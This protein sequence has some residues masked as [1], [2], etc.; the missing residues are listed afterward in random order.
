MSCK[1]RRS[2]KVS[3]DT[4]KNKKIEDCFSQVNKE[5][6]D[7]SSVPQMKNSSRRSPKDITNTQAQRP[8]D[9]AVSQNKVNKEQQDNS[10]VP[11]MK[12]SSRRSSR[13]ITNTQAQIP[14]DQVISQNKVFYVTLDVHHR[15]NK[16]MKH[17]VTGNERDSLSNALDTVKAV[18]E[19]RE[20]QQGKEMLVQGKEGIEGY[21][22]L[23]M[24]LSC[25]PANCHLVITFAQNKNEQSEE[26]QIFGRHD[27]ASTDCVIFFINPIG[28]TRKRIVRRGELHKEGIKLCVYA[29]KGET[30][31]EAVCKD[32][33]FLSFLENDDWKLILNLDSIVEN[34][35]CVDELEGKLFQVEVEK[36]RASRAAATQSCGVVTTQ[37]CDLTTTQNSELEERNTIVLKGQIV[38]Q[39]PSLNREIEKIRKCF[40]KKIKKRQGKK[41]YLIHK[42][43]FGKLTKNATPVKMLKL[44]SHLCDSVGYL[45]WDNNGI[46]GSATCFVFRGLFIFTCRHVIHDIVGKGIEPSEW[47]DIIGRCVRVTFGYEDSQAGGDYFFIKSWFEI[48]D[49][50]LDYAVLELKENGQPVPLGLYNGIGPVP[51][52][53]LI[54]IIGH[55]EGEAKS[56]DACAVIP[57]GLRAQK[58]REHLCAQGFDEHMQFIHMFT[59]RSFQEM[60]PRT[61][62]ITYDT[63]FYFGSSGSPV[64]DSNGSLVA[65]HSAGFRN[66]YQPKFSSIIEFGPTM[67]SIL[68]DIKQKHRTWYEN[69]CVMT[70][71]V[72]MVSDEN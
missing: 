58:Y 29:F 59:Q 43:N 54:Y 14:K 2:Q 62:V 31:K 33:R 21:L 4:K 26:N 10:S 39:Y 16:K 63:S 30:I 35:Q 32:G 61:D 42:T 22:N 37:N 53:G 17:I 9:Q 65:M 68:H 48:S 38:A 40:E 1:K 20:A 34:T 50:T 3:L 46:R 36:K 18:K 52:S 66:Y 6:Q 13:D 57:Q 71:E 70:Q 60:A 45:S 7:N 28:K 41:L 8:K 49:E 69:V 72:E 19:E 15:R 11:Q 5:Q 67:E 56:S 47:A 23:G 64:F 25:L 44:L 27:K 55:P 12:N 24:P 51:L